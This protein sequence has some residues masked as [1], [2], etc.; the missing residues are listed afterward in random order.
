[1]D[2]APGTRPAT[3]IVTPYHRE[4]RAVL[5]RCIRSVSAQGTAADH[6]LVADGHPADWIDAAP[7]RHLRLDREHGDNGNTPRGIGLMLGI[8]EGYANLALLDADNWIDPDHV[9]ACL[10]AAAREPGCDYVIAR[11]RFVRQDGT[12]LRLSDEAVEHHVDTSCFFLRPGSY[13]L[14]PLWGTMPRQLAPLCDRIFY[15]AMKGA[16]MRAAFTERITVNFQ[17]NLRGFYRALGEEPPP[18][19]TDGPDLQAMQR[20]LTSL[21]AEELAQASRRSGVRLDRT[22]GLPP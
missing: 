5:E 13:P 22:D 18:G 17:V 16:G 10:A 19:A 7:V 20:W 11:R 1:M 2:T 9:E 8:A 15:L 4:P 3:L 14:L 21:D 12:P 6:L